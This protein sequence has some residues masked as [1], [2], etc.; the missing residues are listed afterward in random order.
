MTAMPVQPG[1]PFTFGAGGRRRTAEQILMDRRVASSLSAPDF[2]PIASP[3]QGLARVATNLTGALQ[4][5]RADR[6]EAAN[7]AE[8][9]AVLRALMANPDQATATAAAGN[10][11]ISPEV[12]NIARQQLGALMK[13]PTVNDTVADY[14]FRVEKLG[15]KAA[16]EWLARGGDPFVTASLPGG[17]FYAGPQSGFASALGGGQPQVMQAPA[18]TGAPITKQL[19]N[20][21]TAYFVNGDWYDNPEGR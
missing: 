3:W 13:P 12:Q 15:Q 6:A 11:Y 8:S 18:Q 14:N 7:A 20:G 2:S 9:D 1:T 16:D 17:N 19:S 4:G 10:A 5:R 21:Q